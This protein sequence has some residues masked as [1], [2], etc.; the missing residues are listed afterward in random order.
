MECPHDGSLSLTNYIFF[1]T[2]HYAT[3][4]ST[5]QVVLG[6]DLD[7]LKASINP[8]IAAD[9]ARKNLV[10]PGKPRDLGLCCNSPTGNAIW[11]CRI[12]KKDLV[13]SLG[14]M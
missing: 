8:A 13:G 6:Q 14:S 4:Y 12:A 10:I 2:E 3:G 1:G 9:N 7:F 11:V 5:L